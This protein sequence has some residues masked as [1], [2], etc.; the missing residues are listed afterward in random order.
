VLVFNDLVG[1]FER[2]VP[3]FVKRYAELAPVMRKAFMEYR[4]EVKSGKFP[5]PEHVYQ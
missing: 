5:G 3:K 1:L 2:F 4:D